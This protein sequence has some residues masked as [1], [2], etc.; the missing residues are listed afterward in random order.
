VKNPYLKVFVMEGHYDLATPYFAANYA[1][2]HLDLGGKYRQN[3]S[4]ATYESGHMV[5]LDTE[6]LMKM[7]NDEANFIQ[8]AGAGQ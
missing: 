6:S 7:K 4:F 5:Y 1:M 8:K 2:D 3:I